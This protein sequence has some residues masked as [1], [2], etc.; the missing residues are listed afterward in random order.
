M[1]TE[2]IIDA[3]TGNT[4][5]ANQDFSTTGGVA[6]REWM[7]RKFKT[8]ALSNTTVSTVAL[9]LGGTGAPAGT[10]EAYLYTDDGGATSLPDAQVSGSGASDSV[11]CS[12]ISTAA[13]GETITFRW[14]RDCP[15]LA[16]STDYWVVLQ[17]TGYTYANGVTEVRWRT[18]ANGAVGLNECAKYSTNPGVLWSSIGADVGADLEVNSALTV[19]VA[20]KNQVVL[21]LDYTPGSSSEA[22]VMIEFSDQGYD[23]VQESVSEVVGGIRTTTPLENRVTEPTPVRVAIPVGD[24]YMRFSARAVTSATNA[25]LGI[26]ANTAYV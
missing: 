5:D 10:L 16:P 7:A 2:S 8:A 1:A 21:Y 4:P 6:D 25:E 15:V 23:W 12:D 24:C 3:D 11:T 26:V 18:D 20:D 22:R 9:T 13:G 17:S 19:A 14:T